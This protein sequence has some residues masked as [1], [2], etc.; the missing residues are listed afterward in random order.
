MMCLNAVVLS[1]FRVHHPKGGAA[2]ATG[3]SARLP[4]PGKRPHVVQA[5]TQQ[6]HLRYTFTVHT[7]PREAHTTMKDKFV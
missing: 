6:Y 1:D 2:A 4:Q 7:E 5:D 3:R